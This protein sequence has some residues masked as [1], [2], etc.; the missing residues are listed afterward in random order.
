[1]DYTVH[2]ILSILNVSA[3]AC[4]TVHASTLRDLRNRLDLPTQVTIK[5][6]SYLHMFCNIEW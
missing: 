5:P 4:H 2:T 6:H 1:M 3:I